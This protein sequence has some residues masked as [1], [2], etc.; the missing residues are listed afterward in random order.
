MTV[1]LNFFPFLNKICIQERRDSCCEWRIV[2]SEQCKLLGMNYNIS[3]IKESKC[4]SSSCS[5]LNPKLRG[6]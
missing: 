4:L 1:D 2:N 5:I 3:D 6:S